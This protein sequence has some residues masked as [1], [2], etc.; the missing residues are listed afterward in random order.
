M[1]HNITL[2]FS[3]E[4]MRNFVQRLGYETGTFLGNSPNNEFLYTAW[5]PG[6]VSK[7]NPKLHMVFERELKAKLLTL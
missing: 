4:E 3:I 5:K 6:E 7:H 2:S 1:N